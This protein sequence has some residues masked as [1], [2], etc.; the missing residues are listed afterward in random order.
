MGYR[1]FDTT[2]AYQHEGM[3][4]KILKK[5]FDSGKV[6]R[7]EIFITTRLPTFS[8]HP[9]KVEFFLEKSLK[10]LQ[11]D[12]VDLYLIELP[13]CFTF[14]E[15][16]TETV[17]KRLCAFNAEVKGDHIGIWKVK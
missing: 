16:S 7:E 2:F 12:Y 11:L 9:H 15:N 17:S 6:K 1:H 5:W 14:E 13:T 10:N 4:G 3:I 8:V